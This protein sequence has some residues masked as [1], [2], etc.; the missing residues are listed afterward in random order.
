MFRK[1]TD[2]RWY[3]S[4]NLVKDW[5]IVSYDNNAFK[6]YIINDEN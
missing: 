2:T 6:K 4:I 5:A 3:K 1:M